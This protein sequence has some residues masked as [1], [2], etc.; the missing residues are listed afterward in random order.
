MKKQFE[1]LTEINGIK[2]YKGNLIDNGAEKQ[3]IIF[4]DDENFKVPENSDLIKECKRI[5]KNYYEED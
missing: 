1:I 2:F 4:T 5:Y 3:Q